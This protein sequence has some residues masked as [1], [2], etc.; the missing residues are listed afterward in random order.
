MATVP[1]P[2]DAAAHVLAARGWW[3]SAVTVASH[4][5]LW[6]MLLVCRRARGVGGGE[7]PWPESLAAFAFLR[8]L[9]ALPVTPAERESRLGRSRL[10]HVRA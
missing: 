10:A 2:P 3:I 9:T 4:V 1:D 8:L 6:L 5:S 7:V